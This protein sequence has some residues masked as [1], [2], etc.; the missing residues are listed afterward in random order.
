MLLDGNLTKVLNFVLQ[1]LGP[2]KAASQGCFEEAEETRVGF[3]KCE[4]KGSS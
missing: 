1:L 2:F 3:L 4:L